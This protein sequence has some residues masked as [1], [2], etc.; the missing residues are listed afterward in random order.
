MKKWEIISNYTYYEVSDTGNIRKKNTAI[1]APEEN[2][3]RL[4]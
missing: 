1:F 2:A 4:P 3:T